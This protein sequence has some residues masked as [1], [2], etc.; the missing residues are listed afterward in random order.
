MRDYSKLNSFFFVTFTWAPFHTKEFNSRFNLSDLFVKDVILRLFCMWS[1]FC[2][3]KHAGSS[4]HVD[5][6]CSNCEALLVPREQISYIEAFSD[7]SRRIWCRNA[8]GPTEKVF[9]R[10][11][12]IKRHT[13]MTE[14][15]LRA[16]NQAVEVR[17]VQLACLCRGEKRFSELKPFTMGMKIE[18]Y[19]DAHTGE[20]L[21]YRLFTNPGRV[22][23]L[24]W[25]GDQSDHTLSPYVSGPNLDFE[26]GMVDLWESQGHLRFSEDAKEEERESLLIKLKQSRICTRGEY[27]GNE[28]KI[29]LEGHHV[30]K[31]QMVWKSMKPF[32][33]YTFRRSRLSPQK[34]NH[35]GGSCLNALCC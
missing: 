12:H 11:S 32:L 14:E 18:G 20:I 4:H 1:F 15:M 29:M 9:K 27:F 33:V 3:F 23:L 30:G 16:D 7:G 35:K 28:K 25:S 22:A 2:V 13:R 31:E 6:H 26:R 17:H 19:K 10:A 24:S 8:R 21:Q 34:S 5:I